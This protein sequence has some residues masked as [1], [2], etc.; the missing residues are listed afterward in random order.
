MITVDELTFQYRGADAPAVRGIS[1][2]IPSGGIFGFLGPSGA[3]KSTVQKIMTRLLPLQ[4]GDV[5]YDGRSLVSLGRDFFGGVG[6]SFEHP[7]LFPRLTGRENLR[8]LAGLY[9]GRQEDPVALLRRVGLGD[10]IDRRA[11]AYSKGMKQRLVLARALLHR[12][13]YLFLDEPTSGLDPGTAR[14]IVELIREQRERGATILLTTHDMQVAD[15][16][17]DQVGFLHGGQIVACDAP[18]SLK[19]LHGERA[20]RV[21]HRDGDRLTRETLYLDHEEDRARLHRLMD[22][23]HLETLHSQEATL[24]QIFVKLTGQE[25]AA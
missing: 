10:A 25:L 8:A 17:C 24:E 20:V 5:R 3:G 19:L 4:R 9:P 15:I 7:N 21:E 18:R 16:L 2:T 22:R 23:G 13:Q 11:Q 1:F 12:P 14:S 6:V